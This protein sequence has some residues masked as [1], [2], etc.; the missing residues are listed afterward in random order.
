MRFKLQGRTYQATAVF[1]RVPLRDLLALELELE[2]LGRPMKWSEVRLLVY[3]ISQLDDA[4]D[5]PDFLWFLGLLVWGT[6]RIAGEQL[7]FEE[8]IDFPLG[9]LEMLPEPEDRKG[10]K[11][12]DPR[13]ARPGSG[14]AAAPR[15]AA[16]RA[17]KRT[18]SASQ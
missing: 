11:K 3:R 4:Q 7:T 9:E 14:R 17:S 1:D 8:S 10:S 2:T 15:K 5:D 6:R 16:A 13:R 18:T 12:P